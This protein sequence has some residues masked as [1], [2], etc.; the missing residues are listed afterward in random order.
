MSAFRSFRGYLFRP[1]GLSA[2][3]PPPTKGQRRQATGRK[4]QLIYL[5]L[6]GSAV[7]TSSQVMKTSMPK[8]WRPDSRRH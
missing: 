1:P 3:D 6:L 2:P 5:A 8:G 4:I 7:K